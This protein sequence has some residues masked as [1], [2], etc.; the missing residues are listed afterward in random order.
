MCGGRHKELQPAKCVVTRNGKRWQLR[1]ADVG[2]G[3]LLD[4]QR[5]EQLD[6]TAMGLTVTQALSGDSSGTVLYLA[7]ELLSGAAPT[8]RSD[9]YA[10]G[11]MLYPLSVADLPRPLAPGWEPDIDG[12]SEGHTAELQSLNRIVYA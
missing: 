3:R 5:L 9:I 10:L 12:R 8:V 11:L 2:S 1:L 6:I 7:P 4:P